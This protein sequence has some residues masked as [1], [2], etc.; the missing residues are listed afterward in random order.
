M[1]D[2][3][4]YPQSLHYCRSLSCNRFSL[5]KALHGVE[6]NC[7]ELGP[8]CRIEAAVMAAL[9]HDTVDDTSISLEEIYDDFGSRVAQIVGQVG[10]LS[11]TTQLLR[12]RRRTDVSASNFPSRSALL[13]TQSNHATAAPRLTHLESAH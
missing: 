10:Q 1:A 7:D 11:T 13:H 4:L 12:R 5:P 8:F 6:S 2:H 9:L 3:R